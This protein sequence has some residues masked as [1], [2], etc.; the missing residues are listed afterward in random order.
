MMIPVGKVD[1]EG[2]VGLGVAGARKVE[3]Y[4]L[5]RKNTTASHSSKNWRTY[6]AATQYTLHNLETD[7]TV[8]AM[9]C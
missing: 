7:H 1:L 9:T 5:S 2:L 6:R 4:M 8:T 3:I